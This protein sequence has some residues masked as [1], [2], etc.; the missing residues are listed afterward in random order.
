MRRVPDTI[1]TVTA[2]PLAGRTLRELQQK[3]L[4]EFVGRGWR[5]PRFP[6]MT[7]FIDGYGML[8]VHLY[9]DDRIA[10]GKQKRAFAYTAN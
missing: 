7:K 10:R 4:Y 9:A 3:H 8:S 1:A 5:G 2:G 6:V